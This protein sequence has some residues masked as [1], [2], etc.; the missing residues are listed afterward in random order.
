MEEKKDLV[1]LRSLEYVLID[2]QEIPVSKIIKI[3]RA[4][5]P[6]LRFNAF[7]LEENIVIAGETINFGELY[8]AIQDNRVDFVAV[9]DGD[10]LFHENKN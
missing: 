9:Q 3:Y 2:G 1:D 6:K 4:T 10:K 8:A 5:K 7:K